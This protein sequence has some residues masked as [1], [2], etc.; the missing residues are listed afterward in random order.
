MTN[1]TIAKNIGNASVTSRSAWLAWLFRSTLGDLDCP[2]TLALHAAAAQNLP[3]QDRGQN[4]RRTPPVRARCVH[5]SGR[6]PGSETWTTRF[7][8]RKMPPEP[9][10]H[11][12]RP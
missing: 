9:V 8:K 7:E 12:L 1:A 6:E 4:C 10:L 2:G 11:A 3:L 5:T